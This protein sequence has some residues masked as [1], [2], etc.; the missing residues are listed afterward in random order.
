M[1]DRSL[2]GII[3]RHEKRK[4][5]WLQKI[6]QSLFADRPAD[7]PACGIHELSSTVDGDGAVPVV[8]NLGKDV[9][10]VVVVGQEVVDSIVDYKHMRAL[11]QDVCDDLKLF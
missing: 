3:E 8:A 11:I 7:F 1:A 9:M 2:A 10:L 5:Y 6:I 4:C